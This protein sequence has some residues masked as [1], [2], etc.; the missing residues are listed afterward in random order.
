MIVD[1]TVN[2]IIIPSV[3]STSVRRTPPVPGSRVGAANTIRLFFP[4][5]PA[6][7]YAIWLMGLPTD[8]APGEADTL[9]DFDADDLVKYEGPCGDG[10][11]SKEEK[12]GSDSSLF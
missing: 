3:T 8:R 9:V 4:P 12:R 6:S 7:L 5:P 10:E 2:D 1:G 11:F